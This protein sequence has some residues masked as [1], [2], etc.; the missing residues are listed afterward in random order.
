MT[1]VAS[2]PSFANLNRPA[3]GLNANSMHA[4]NP[5]HPDDARS[6]F[7]PRKPLQR[8]NSSSSVSSNSSVSSSTGTIVNG[9][10]ASGASAV[11]GD[12]NGLFKRRGQPQQKGQWSQQPQSVLKP[13]GADFSRPPGAR[14]VQSNGNGAP[15]PMHQG[16]M[17]MGPQGQVAQQGAMSRP[18]ADP[19]GGMQP[20]VQPVLYLLSLNG[21]FERKTISVPYYPET[22]RIGRQTNART[23]PTPVN[24]YFD[25]KVLSRQHAEIYADRSSGKIWIRDVK[26][27]NG[28]F[29][30]GTRLSQEN[31][32]SEPH[33]LQ[34][35]DHL[36]LGIDIVNEDQK[37]VVHHKVAAKVEHAGFLNPTHNIMDMSFGDMDPTGGQMMLAQ[38]GGMQARGRNGNQPQMGNNGRMAP[39]AGMPGAQQNG[40]LPRNGMWM[41]QPSTEAIVKKLHQ[42]MRAAKLQ[43]NDLQ[44]TAHFLDA[45]MGKEDVRMTDRPETQEPTKQHAVNGGMFRSEVSKARFSDP[46]APPPQQPLPEKPD[47]ARPNGDA[48]P[49]KR[50]STERPKSQSSPVRQDNLSHILQ[51]TETLNFAK[52]EIEVQ[53]ARIRDLEMIAQKERESRESAEALVR[54]LEDAAMAHTNGIAKTSLE[55]DILA[56]AFELPTEAPAPA[57]TCPKQAIQNEASRAAS[58]MP[59]SAAADAAAEAASKLQAK[60]DAIVKEMR[61]LRDDLE[62]QRKRAEEAEA[63]R[64]V[65]RKSL[66]EMI[67]QLRQRDEEIKR[68]SEAP[69]ARSRSSRRRDRNDTITEHIKPKPFVGSFPETPTTTGIPEHMES[70]GPPPSGSERTSV[71]LAEDKPTLS[72]SSTITPLSSSLHS[73]RETAAVQAAPYASMLGVVLLGVGLMA[74]INGWQPQ[75]QLDR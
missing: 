2:P 51:L 44:R 38:M 27:S 50:G 71:D 57:A 30:N 73:S 22:L 21:T 3:W 62:T 28:T 20:A 31:R 26:S 41:S 52:K 34:T 54:K 33:E 63:E 47:V 6:M 61:D 15:P 29:V 16:A 1:A 45:L 64:D 68:L 18:V 17:M 12:A 53:G 72:R 49:L 74:W 55:G 8:T 7:T 43:S 66:A 65:D 69:K 25:S 35:Q 19:M 60:L 56:E 23:V 14:S 10:H 39:A 40:L 24:G 5:H 58:Q 36:E 37:S 46:P 48:P 13:D 9:G 42:E 32:E 67:L 70:K 59:D 11:N 4:P 75:P